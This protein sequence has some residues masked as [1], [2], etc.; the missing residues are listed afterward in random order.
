MREII[1]FEPPETIVLT[2]QG[3]L[4]P[5]ETV[6]MFE[7]WVQLVGQEK[8]VKVLIDLSKTKEI[9]PKAREVLRKRG[10]QFPVSKLAF[11]GASAKIRIL[12]GII[13]KIVSNVDK[14]IFVKTEEEARAWLAEEQ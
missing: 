1:T 4:D 9:P 14:S 3:I 2:F 8:K 11:F 5:D 6:G 12:A 10:G 7:K 13:I